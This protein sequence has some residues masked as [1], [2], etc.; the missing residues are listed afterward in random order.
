VVTTPTPP[1]A[2]DK[3]RPQRRSTSLA[4]NSAT[5]SFMISDL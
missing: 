4:P 2:S 1:Q 3:V 5:L